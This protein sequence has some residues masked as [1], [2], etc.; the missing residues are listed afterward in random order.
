VTQSANGGH[1]IQITAGTGSAS[2]GNVGGIG[3]IANGGD[4]GAASGIGGAGG[5]FQGGDGGTVGGTGIQ[6]T[7]GFPSGTALLAIA[8]GSVA[9]YFEGDVHVT[10][11]LSKSGGSFQIDHPLD[12]ENKYLYHSFVESPDMMNVYNGNVTTDS[13]GFA[14]ITMPDWFEALNG[15]F[16]YQLT[17]IGQPAQV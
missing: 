13:R 8:N 16:R 7:A 1:G 10:G 3:I 2:T 5:V 6:A 4:A 15:D 11:T 12:P 14:H 17:T 9:G